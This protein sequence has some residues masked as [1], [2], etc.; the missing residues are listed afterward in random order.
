M[1]I[2]LTKKAGTDVSTKPIN[3][4]PRRQF[5]KIAIVASSLVMIR[6]YNHNSREEGESENYKL[7]KKEVPEKKDDLEKPSLSDGTPIVRGKGSVTELDE[8]AH[9][10]MM[11]RLKISEMFLF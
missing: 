4:L 3:K 5:I 8:P 9:K 11:E 1:N 2:Q 10:S 6:A 7:V